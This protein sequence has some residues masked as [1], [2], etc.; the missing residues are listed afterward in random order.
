MTEEFPCT[1]MLKENEILKGC[2]DRNYRIQD[3]EYAKVIKFLGAGAFGEVYEVSMLKSK[4]ELAVKVVKF[5]LWQEDR[6]KRNKEVVELADEGLLAL[7]MG[8]HSNLCSVYTLELGQGLHTGEFM[9]FMDLCVGMDLV[10]YIDESEE[11]SVYTK[12][13]G[14]VLH[15]Q[16][17]IYSLMKQLFEVIHD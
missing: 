9:V 17:E 1:R 16:I 10:K 4:K 7:R 6:T 8:K 14:D 15:F 5:E 13:S 11:K 12:H 2:L 3:E